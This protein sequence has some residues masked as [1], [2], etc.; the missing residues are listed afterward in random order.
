MQMTLSP[1]FW[2]SIASKTVLGVAL[3][4]SLAGATTASAQ[5]P[6]DGATLDA[7][8]LKSQKTPVQ[9][10]GDQTVTLDGALLQV[11]RT[12]INASGNCKVQVMNSRVVG[13]IAVVATGNAEITFENAIVEGSLQLMGNTTASFKSSTVTGKVRKLQSAAVKDLGHNVWH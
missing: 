1:T 2:R 3:I 9:C 12:A 10:T 5:S 13:K 4:G 6:A 8:K 7:T 11:G